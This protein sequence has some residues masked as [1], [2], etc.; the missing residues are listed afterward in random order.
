MCRQLHFAMTRII[1]ITL[2]MIISGCD[3]TGFIYNHGDSLIN[4]QAR[5]YFDLSSEQKPGVKS[6]INAWLSWHRRTQLLCYANLIDEFESRARQ[7][8]SRADLTWLESEISTSYATSL[9]RAMIP[10]A[11]T[12]STLNA[13]QVAHLEKRLAKYQE[14]LIRKYGLDYQ[15]LQS[16]RAKKTI[17]GLKKWFGRLSRA[18]LTW[19]KQHSDAL[20]NGYRPW[21][22]Y[23][24]LR[25]RTLIRLLR[26]YTDANTIIQI[27]KPMWTDTEASMTYDS[28]ALMEELRSQSMDMAV[29]FYATATP[30]QKN[31]FWNQ[32]RNYRDDFRHLA[33]VDINAT[34]DAQTL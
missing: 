31:H 34:C 20:P 17:R 3:A 22:E 33:Q 21:L 7:T 12:L 8:L 28:Q 13:E 19:V 14:K 18:Q 16:R 24:A 32:L 6:D 2:C 26:S 30:R 11:Q 25:D 9:S 23:R 29:G 27:I 10:A 5:R 4:F 15:G 1:I